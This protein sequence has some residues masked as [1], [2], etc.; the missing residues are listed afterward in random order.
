[1][2]RGGVGGV[3][4]LDWSGAGVS[5]IQV[6]PA[7]PPESYGIR[8]P[9]VEVADWNIGSSPE[10]RVATPIICWVLAASPKKK[11]IKKSRVY[12]F[13]SSF[14]CGKLHNCHM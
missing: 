9:I 13:A 14:C 10:G 6:A 12:R 11:E 8:S 2:V 7:P 1:M 3:L 5:E 4:G